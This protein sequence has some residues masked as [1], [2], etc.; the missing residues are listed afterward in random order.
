MS[1]TAMYNIT[2]ASTAAA[3]YTLTATP[4]GRM[5]GDG[6][7]NLTLDSTGLRDRTGT[8]DINLCWGR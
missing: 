3:T 8:L 1:G 2:A 4:V 7:G 6:C 5:D